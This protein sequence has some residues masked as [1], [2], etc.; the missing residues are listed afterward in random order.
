MNSYW[1]L[2]FVVTPATVLAVGY[3]LYLLDERSF[4]R[5]QDRTPAE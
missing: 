2:A 4:R 3:V 5:R 1:F